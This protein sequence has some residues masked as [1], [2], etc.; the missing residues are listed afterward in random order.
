MEVMCKQCGIVFIAQQKEIKR[1]NGKY[2]SSACCYAYRR[3][4][5]VAERII[6]TCDNP[7][8]KKEFERLPGRV[9]TNNKCNKS[10]L[11]FCSRKCKDQAQ[12]I[13]IG[14]REMW[15]DHFGLGEGR[16]DYRERALAFYGEICCV[17]AYHNDARML[18]VDHK[19]SD[20]ANN[21]LSNLQVLCV[22]CHALK[23]RKVPYHD[24]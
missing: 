23:T 12:K 18:D 11:R 24:R 1:G 6:L 15:P 7:A 21:A 13:D 14:L 20:R 16:H 17:C 5:K 3:G 2:C 9:A 4:K 19:D 8:C 22:W 10:K